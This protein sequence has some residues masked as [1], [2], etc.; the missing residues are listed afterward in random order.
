MK[1]VHFL[2]A[3]IATA[4]AAPVQQLD[5]RLVLYTVSNPLLQVVR[6]VDI[7]AK[8]L[9]FSYGPGTGGGPPSP[10][11]V[12]GLT[13]VSTD[14]LITNAEVAAQGVVDLGDKSAIDDN[15]AA[16]NG[17]QTLEDYTKLYEGYWAATSAPTGVSPGLLTN[18]TQ[19]L[20]FSMQRLST[21]PYAVRRL[22]PGETLPFSVEDTIV[23]NL[24]GTDNGS[25]V[26]VGIDLD[27]LLSQGR[28]FYVDHSV[29]KD[30]ETE[31]SANHAGGCDA[32]FFIH[33]TNGQFL[34]LAIR[35]NYQ[36][37]LI[38]TPHDSF[39]DWMLAKIMFNADDLFMA[40]FYHFSGSHFV[41]EA[42]FQAAV[43]TLS[44]EHPVLAILR[45]LMYGAFGIRPLAVDILF[46]V[47]GLIDRHFGYS[48]RAAESYS[49]YLYESGISGAVQANYFKANLKRRGLIESTFG[50]AL[51]HFPFYEDA[52]PLWNA[53]HTFMTALVHSYYPNDASIAAD[54]EILD[55]MDEA[56]GSAE[57]VDFPN[58]ATMNSRAKLIDVLTHVA[59][60]VSTA[61]HVVN[62][63]ALITAGAVLP[64]NPGALFHPIPT[65]KGET[66]VAKY[67][68]DVDKSI[69]YIFNTGLFSRPLLAGTDRTIVHMFDDPVML[70]RMKPAV[71]TANNV[72]KATMEARSTVVKNRQLDSNGLS[73]G[74][75][76]VWK[77]LDPDVAPWSL[78][79]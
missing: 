23:K 55:W 24:T 36:S 62:T 1:P 14:R 74:M 45:R 6:N 3:Y 59:H 73:Q 40:Q 61:H 44:E 18:Y 10:G 52:L 26:I 5:K 19:D 48:G 50:P 46:P 54:N 21:N 78:T 72:F 37:N 41:S 58:R 64:L 69:A 17:L 22:A 66:N 35:T 31:Q 20:L 77:T 2:A 71:R 27:T 30:F 57:V 53:M 49:N 68:P 33:P 67:L 70:L 63:N 25:E 32:Y 42:I 13:A 60:L 75:P 76:F 28:L 11:G 47:G 56:N 39:E 65:A 43:R 34:P 16:L 79:V 38:Y 4:A 29:L 8:R 15:K 7:T 51:T 12:L 9:L